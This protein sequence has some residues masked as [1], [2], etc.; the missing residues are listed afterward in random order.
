MPLDILP[1]LLDVPSGALE[2]SLGGSRT[3]SG[4]K[5][6]LELANHPIKYRQ[7]LSN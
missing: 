6:R 5:E 7:L 2:A 3:T 4:E 1:V